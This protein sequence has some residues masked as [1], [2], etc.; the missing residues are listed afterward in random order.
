M[1]KIL[2]ILGTIILMTSASIGVVSCSSGQQKVNIPATL[3]QE[4][5]ALINFA[6]ANGIN[7]GEINENNWSFQNKTVQDNQELIDFTFEENHNVNNIKNESQLLKQFK[8]NMIYHLDSQKFN[9]IGEPFNKP[10]LIPGYYQPSLNVPSIITGH[11]NDF[12]ISASESALGQLA[13]EIE[14]RDMKLPKLFNHMNWKN[15]KNFKGLKIA[16]LLKLVDK[17]TAWQLPEVGY[18][19]SIHIVKE[20]DSYKI[21]WTNLDND[22]DKKALPETNGDLTSIF[23]KRSAK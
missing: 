3:K 23:W 6:A 14:E 7:E 22:Q 15:A 2:S 5:D 19:A 4:Q 9:L 18:M 8:G 13:K 12:T 17:P 20:N 10:I 16:D 11:T 1:K 21:A